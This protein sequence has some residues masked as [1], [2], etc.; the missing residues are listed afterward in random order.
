[1]TG[2]SH[3]LNTSLNVWRQSKTADGSGG[4]TITWA[5][6]GAVDCKVDQSTPAEQMAAMQAGA[7][8]THNIYLAT[9][10]DVQRNDRLAA[11]G[12]NPSTD[13]G[14]YHV[15][16]TAEPSSPRYLKAVCERVEA[17]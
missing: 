15:V 8:H 6:Q 4:S 7:M 2:I 16:G 5:N 3:W 14:Y 12:V 10:T 9:G 1:M 11:T 13:K 17:T